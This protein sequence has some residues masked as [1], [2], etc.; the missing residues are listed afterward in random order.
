LTPSLFLFF[1]L[2]ALLGIF[3]L[4]SMASSCRKLRKN[5][6]LKQL[7]SIGK[8]FYYGYLH[9]IFFPKQDLE[10]YLFSAVCAQNICR[11]LYALFALFWLI[12]SDFFSMN[13]QIWVGSILFII[14]L[15]A[16][17]D[18][19]SRWFGVK[20][21]ISVLKTLAPIA[22]F[23]LILAFPFSYAFL[24]LF[25]YPIQNVYFD[26]ETESQAKRDLIEIIQDTEIEP[27][28]EP[29]DR[30]VIESMVKFHHRI[31]REVMVPR[32]DVYALPDNTTIKEAARLLDVEGFSRIPVYKNNVDNIVGLLMYKDVV[33]KFLEYEQEGNNPSVLEAPIETISKEVFYTP[34][35]KKISHLLQ[36]FK[37]KQTHMAVVVDEYGGTE[38]IITIE[39]LLEEIVGDIAD[40]YDQEEELF[41]AQPDGS[42]VIDARMNIDDIESELNFKIPQEGDYDTLGGYLF[43]RTGRIPPKGFII[44]LDDCEIQVLHS[45]ER[46]VDKVKIIP[47]QKKQDHES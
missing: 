3:A 23:F 9:K 15:I 45:D 10:T 6:A 43:H 47:L 38:G 17:G 24:K 40:E 46:S 4:T 1:S 22:S 21:P 7:Q 16:F 35:T 34:E 11:F 30:K 8:L 5:E 2:V 29:I 42:W 19:F 25:R 12:S 31:A 41:K 44:Y 33:H 32:V 13:L 28:L 20:Y 26:Y 36:E 27:S 14:F 18:L 37:T 39:D